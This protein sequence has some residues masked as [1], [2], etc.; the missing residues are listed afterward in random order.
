M[1]PADQ[2]LGADQPLGREL[3]DRLVVEDELV[4]AKGVS[5]RALELD[6]LDHRRVHLRFEHLLLTAPL[7]LRA[8][9]GEVCVSQQVIVGLRADRNTDAR[10]DEELAALELKRL[11][12]RLEDSIGD[13]GDAL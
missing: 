4:L 2:R 8:I 6:A 3:E 9:E 12:H 7:R 1:L 13:V 10:A 5:E 11:V